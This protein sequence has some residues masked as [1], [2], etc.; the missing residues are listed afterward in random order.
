MKLLHKQRKGITELKR[1]IMGFFVVLIAIAVVFTAFGT[2][3][4]IQA[5]N[6]DL[7]CLAGG[8]NC[9]LTENATSTMEGAVNDIV[10][11]MPL[12][13]LVIVAGVVIAY[14]SGAFKGV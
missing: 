12:L 4:D 3:S 8:V 6:S 10:G 5:D 1:P 14:T 2:I 7:T 11:W 9:T 13:A